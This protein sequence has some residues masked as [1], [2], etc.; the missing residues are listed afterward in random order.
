MSS[1]RIPYLGVVV[2]MTDAYRAAAQDKRPR[3][4]DTY[5]LERLEEAFGV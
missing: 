1:L 4:V 3:G 5:T 2:A